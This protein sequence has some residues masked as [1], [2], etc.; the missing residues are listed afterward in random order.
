MPHKRF[1]F[2]NKSV[3][4]GMRLS[5]S[6]GFSIILLAGRSFA[7]EIENEKENERENEREREA[8][9]SGRLP[10]GEATYDIIPVKSRTPTYLYPALR[11]SV[12]ESGT[13]SEACRGSTA[14]RVQ[15]YQTVLYATIATISTVCKIFLNNF[16]KNL[17]NLGNLKLK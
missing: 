2:R 8:E 7:R 10:E 9:A 16:I 4:F 1:F 11:A 6:E 17:R 3:F 13:G 5:D 15:Y 14:T 12:L